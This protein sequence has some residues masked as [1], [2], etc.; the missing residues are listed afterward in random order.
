M[1]MSKG[2]VAVVV[3]GSLA[4]I[5]GCR[6][7]GPAERAGRDVD[8]AVERVGIELGKAGDRM[9]EVVKKLDR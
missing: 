6:K 9:G 7:E 8:R 3:F 5:C 2:I 1:N 4:G